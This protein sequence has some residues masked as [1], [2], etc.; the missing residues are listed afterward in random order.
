MGGF[1]Y[2]GDQKKHMAY[3]WLDPR[4]QMAMDALVRVGMVYCRARKHAAFFRM[5]AKEG[6]RSRIIQV[7]DVA[8]DQVIENRVVKVVTQL[9]AGMFKGD[10]TVEETFRHQLRGG[11]WTPELY[12]RITVS[13]KAAKLL[14]DDYGEL[15]YGFNGKV[16]SILILASPCCVGCK[17][18]GH[19]LSV[20]KLA[21]AFDLLNKLLPAAQAVGEGVNAG[22]GKQKEKSAPKAPKPSPPLAT[23]KEDVM[24]DGSQPGEE[25]VAMGVAE[26]SEEEEDKSEGDASDESKSDTE[27][28]ASEP[29]NKR[30]RKD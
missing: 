10:V 2:D 5:L 17:A 30:Q 8:R 20:C 3:G 19:F 13:E 9:G 15:K 21:H 27:S 26:D 1:V 23:S 11:K 24:V 12:L 18:R 29:A 4:G 14:T 28:N 16:E 7:R 6:Q 25:D 22:K